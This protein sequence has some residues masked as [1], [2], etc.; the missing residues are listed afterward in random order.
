MT[1][2]LP[3]VILASQS[4][5]RRDL[6]ARTGLAFDIVARETEE[7]LDAPLPPEELCLVNARAKAAAVAKEYPC[8][9]VIGA[10]T[11]V[12]DGKTPLGKPADL[13]EARDML[14]RL[15]GKLH[16]V[17]TAVSI[18]S[19][20]ENREFAETTRVEFKPLAEE[21][22]NLYLSLVNVLDKAGSYAL[23][24]HGDIIIAKVTGDA[25]NVI[26]LPVNRLA[27]ELQRIGYQL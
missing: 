20:L 11:L 10:D 25:D 14:R 6:L 21:D 13:D 2:H 23:Q 12:F 18:L 5:R 19:P 15:S 26:G 8:S 24:E 27:D 4:P 9:T 1:V 22:I 17:C 16:T 7:I 3:P